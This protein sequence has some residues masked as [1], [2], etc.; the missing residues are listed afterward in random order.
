MSTKC[1]VAIKK[2]QSVTLIATGGMNLHIWLT[3]PAH[4]CMMDC[5]SASLRQFS[6]STGSVVEHC[7]STLYSPGVRNTTV[8]SWY[9]LADSGSAVRTI[10]EKKN[11]V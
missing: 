7:I 8:H 6:S 1:N 11:L 9:A 2:T 10:L 3:S 4:V 5:W